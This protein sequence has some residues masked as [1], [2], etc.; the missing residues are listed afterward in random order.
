MTYKRHLWSTDLALANLQM[1]ANLIISHFL[2][3]SSIIPNLGSLCHPH[4]LEEAPV[5]H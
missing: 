2:S 3:I 5:A 1:L 4:G